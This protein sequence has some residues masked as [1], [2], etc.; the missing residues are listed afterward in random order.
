M[1]DKLKMYCISIDEKD[2]NLI[3][4]L[5]YIPV[6]L[7]DSPFSDKWLNDSKG[8]NISRKNKWYTELT[9][10]YYFWKN[11][12][13]YI[14]EET[15]I[16]FSAYRDIWV[17]SKE[18]RNYS[19]DPTNFQKK[20]TDRYKEIN[21]IA[22]K[23]IPNEWMGFETILGD[24]LF[25]NEIKLMKII[26][27]GK[28]SLLRNPKAIF[29]SG[30][31]IRW[32]FDMFHGNGL[33]DKAANLLEVSERKDFI[34]YIKMNVSFNRGNMFICKSKNTMNK[35]YNSLFPWLER[36]EKIFGFDLKGYGQTRIY[37]YLAERYIPFWFKK[38]SKCLIWPALSF[39]IPRKKIRN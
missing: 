4:S 6:G 28:L 2:L 35:F 39:N 21:D 20:N 14:S 11:E 36:C 27:Y 33:I 24:E 5:G 30:R 17:N 8:D 22:L 26:K 13:P 34:E 3:E 1:T 29:K 16:G 12:L 15:W 7:G 9:F 18:F 23:K 31:T 37:A 25:L 10:H 38:Y 32:H 19:N